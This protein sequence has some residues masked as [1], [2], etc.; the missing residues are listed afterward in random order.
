M[1]LAAL[2]QATE[3][4]PLPPT[5]ADKQTR[6]EAEQLKLALENQHEQWLQLPITKTLLSQL[7]VAI[8]DRQEKATEI[9]TDSITTTKLL[10]EAKTL[11][12]LVSYVISLDSSKLAL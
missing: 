4:N 10:S 8:R 9:C 12:K 7:H 3:G 11:T 2:T 1:N 6:H 5:D